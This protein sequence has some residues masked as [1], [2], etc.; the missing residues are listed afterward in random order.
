MMCL[1]GTVDG[2]GIGEIPSIQDFSPNQSKTYTVKTYSQL[3]LRTKYN[4]GQTFGVPEGF[5]DGN[6]SNN[7]ATATIKVVDPSRRNPLLLQTT[8]TNAQPAR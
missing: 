7:T 6:L 8:L 3:Q 4:Y 1:K 2:T 5:I